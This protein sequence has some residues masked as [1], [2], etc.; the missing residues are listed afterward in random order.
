MPFGGVLF[1][2]SALAVKVRL[3]V[4]S[5]V[6]FG[7]VLFADRISFGIGSTRTTSASPVPFGGVLFADKDV[8]T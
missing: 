2:D 8:I 1:A 6:P 4:A 5:P 7:G 3:E